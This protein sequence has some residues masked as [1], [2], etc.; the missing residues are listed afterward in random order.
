MCISLRLYTVFCFCDLDLDLDLTNTDILK[1]Y[2]RT[3][4]EVSR[5]R[6]SKVRAQTRQTQRE[7]RVTRPNA[8]H[9]AAF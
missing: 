6:L 8:L 1:M 3:E 2:P 7:T 4:N 5:S 9:T